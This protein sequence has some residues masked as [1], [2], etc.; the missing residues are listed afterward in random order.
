MDPLTISV[1]LRVL[2]ETGKIT[3]AILKKCNTPKEQEM[4]AMR[5]GKDDALPAVKLHV[6]GYYYCTFKYYGLPTPFFLVKDM[7]G[8]T[9][10]IQLDAP[11]VLAVLKAVYP[12]A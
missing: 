1:C 12:V 3:D 7:D 5:N 10:G 8:V 2:I 4:L 11:L 6:D 9:R